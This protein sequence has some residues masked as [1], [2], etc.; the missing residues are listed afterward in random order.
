[1]VVGL[2]VGLRAE[3]PQ[4]KPSDDAKKTATQTNPST[5]P[6]PNAPAPKVMPKSD[7]PPTSTTTG[8]EFRSDDLL[9]GRIVLTAERYQELLR[10]IEQLEGQLKPARPIAPSACRLSGRV[11]G[12][13]VH[14]QAIFEFRTERERTLV[15]LSCPQANPTAAALDGKLPLLLPVEDGFVVQVDKADAH[16]L[17]LDMDVPLS[18]KGNERG[19]TLDLPHAAITTLTLDLPEFVK[20]AHLLTDL[21]KDRPGGKVVVARPGEPKW[22]R[23]DVGALGPVKRLE[24][25]WKGQA[26]APAGPPLL[27]AEGRVNVRIDPGATVID[28]ELTLRTLRGQAQEWRL[29]V[30]ADAVVEVLEQPASPGVQATVDPVN[31]KTPVARVVR[32]SE[33]TSESFKV[34][35]HA[36]QKRGNGPLR[37]GPF[38]V[39]G[40][41]RERG[42]IL[43]SAPPDL[44][45]RYQILA[46]V[47]QRE[48][49]AEELRRDPRP[50]D[51]FSY[52]SMPG[53][54][55]PAAPPTPLLDIGVETIKGV[56]EM[57]RVV[58]TVRLTERGWQVTT[59][60]DAK[61]IPSADRLEIQLPAGFQLDERL[62]AK[63]PGLV[64]NVEVSAERVALLSLV[65][66]SEPFHL[67]LEGT[68]PAPA[69][70][71]QHAVLDLPM[72]RN[73]L[74]R[75][76]QV[77]VI[78]PETLTFVPLRVDEVEA[79]DHQHT[80]S[81]EQMPARVE[82]A[83]RVHEPDLPVDSVADIM[84][85]GR[86]VRVRQ[87]LRL[88]FPKTPPASVILR[89]PAALGNLVRIVDGGRSQREAVYSEATSSWTWNVALAGAVGKEHVLTLDYALRLPEGGGSA[90]LSV[91]F[92]MA[93][94]ATRSEM[95][96]RLWC[97]S[98]LRVELGAGPWEERPTEVVADQQSLPALVARC[99][100]LDA[101]LPLRV[102]EETV[103]GA[104]AAVER[105]LV[106]VQITEGGYQEYRTSLLLSELSARQL[107][108][109]W[110]VAVSTLSL[111]VFVDGKLLTRWE[112][113]D[114]SGQRAANGRMTRLTLTTPLAGK[115]SVVDFVYQAAP[116]RLAGNHLLQSTLIVPV[117]RGDLG[118]APVRWQVAL[119]ASWVPIA[120]SGSLAAEQQWGWR[121]WLLAPRPALA[122]GDLERWFFGAEAVVH[123]DE[124]QPWGGI[125][126]TGWR[127]GLE[128]L[129]LYHAPQQAWLLACSLVLLGI[130]LSFYFLPLPRGL[131]LG[132]TMLLVLAL[133]SAG[134]LWPGLLSALIY[135]C[136]PGALVLLAAIGW[137]WLLHRRYR[138]QLVFMPGFARLKASS[139]VT[140]GSSVVR[141]RT[142]PSTVDN[143]PGAGNGE[144]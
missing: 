19:F 141:K 119:P 118:Q 16:T 117:P 41:F 96:A 10:K 99:P 38:A 136:E 114:D 39:E 68:L 115:S 27:A 69:A 125:S 60:L 55:K 95:K 40:A 81:F 56:I 25:F 46:A 98:G 9:G 74:D 126:F 92:V 14:F 110:P 73:T 111:K 52:W 88:Q 87:R 85:E 30:P 54:D 36:G 142:E 33:P 109:E 2:A 128:P 21:I 133:S 84:L 63:H 12:D 53:S 26:A 130:G 82:V 48:A 8:D 17:S 72:P 62:A 6:D 71:A 79:G 70:D 124:Q 44:R 35:V 94:Q 86:Q 90:T 47:G 43:V 31:P 22:N 144:S 1:L 131:F 132:A 66:R 134:L 105:A 13:I 65:P 104:T 97:D 140:R 57:T 112:A 24:V 15:A 77:T 83:W 102:W 93:E 5:P 51:A 45:L 32:L 7:Q 61:P 113:I 78:L 116:G 50:R 58:H 127:N 137:Q 29:V 42:S 123:L 101:P 89:V 34:M 11:E 64:Q 143:P 67:T 23:L 80:W 103:A 3:E 37:V 129:R 18:A 76:G 120:F 59:E 20:D 106:R 135:G 108:V 122:P 138:R 100:R 107:S 139:S 28:A 91:P 49:T 75:G 121:G 4:R